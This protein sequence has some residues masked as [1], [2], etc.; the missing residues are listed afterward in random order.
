M[1]PPNFRQNGTVPATDEQS[2]SMMTLITKKASG[3][4]PPSV[5]LPMPGGDYAAAEP[6]SHTPRGGM[7]LR[8]RSE[9]IHGDHDDAEYPM[10][11]FPP[12]HTSAAFEAVAVRKSLILTPAEVYAECAHHGEEK[13]QFGWLK[14]LVLS[15]IAGCYVGFG[16]TICLMV[17]GNVGTDIY[18]DH[19]GLFSLVFGAVG[20]PAAF[21][22]IVV[23]GAELFT[24]MCAYATAAWWEGRLGMLSCIRWGG[25][26]GIGVR[27]S[28]GVG[29]VG[30]LSVRLRR[31]GAG[32]LGTRARGHW[33]GGQ[34]GGLECAGRRR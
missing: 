29:R 15:V 23:C 12:A 34:R 2:P 8:R 16:F 5:R 30:W 31:R 32:A 17:G 10:P 24:S 1:A 6:G 7:G 14:L 13:A 25:G 26:A 20:F 18:T 22:M 27:R 11:R 19:P 3:E 28:R 21:T 9:R 33:A 4:A